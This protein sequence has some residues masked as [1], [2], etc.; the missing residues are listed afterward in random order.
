MGMF[1]S[2]PYS[3]SAL[4]K[5]NNQMEELEKSKKRIFLGYLPLEMKT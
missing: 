3:L 4:S 5:I 1:E 2:H